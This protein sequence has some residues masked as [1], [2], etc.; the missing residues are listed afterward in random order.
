MEDER[1]TNNWTYPLF[2]P[3]FSSKG[4]GV[5]TFDVGAYQIENGK[6]RP[7]LNIPEAQQ[8]QLRAVRRRGREH[9]CQ[10]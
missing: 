7:C 6:T 5:I 4:G 3:P 10:R 9:S 2:P 1:N 8:A